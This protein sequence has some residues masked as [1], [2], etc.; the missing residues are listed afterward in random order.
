MTEWPRDTYKL[1]IFHRFRAILFAETKK[2]LYQGP[3]PG[4]SREGSP[5][6]QRADKWLAEDSRM[7]LD[8]REPENPT[9]FLLT[10]TCFIFF[11]ETSV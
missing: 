5:G 7:D 4:P 2:C 10:R 9:D 11:V 1:F 6:G 8:Y 3:S